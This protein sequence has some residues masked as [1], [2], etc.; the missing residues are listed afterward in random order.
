MNLPGLRRLLAGD[1]MLG[2]GVAR[3]LAGNELEIR[4]GA[5]GGS[6]GAPG[7]P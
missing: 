2:T 3:V 5:T 7:V 6:H 4:L 1:V